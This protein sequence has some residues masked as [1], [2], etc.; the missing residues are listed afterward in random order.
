MS[1]LTYNNILQF[2]NILLITIKYEIITDYLKFINFISSTKILL[3]NY[4]SQLKRMSKRF[5]TITFNIYNNN[6]DG[7]YTHT[8]LKNAKSET[9]IVSK[10]VLILAIREINN[11]EKIK[12]ILIN[13]IILTIQKTN[14]I[15]RIDQTSIITKQILFESTNS[16]ELI[17]FEQDYNPLKDSDYQKYLKSYNI[18]MDINDLYKS[19][20]KLNNISIEIIDKNDIKNDLLDISK[21]IN[22][23]ILNLDN[24]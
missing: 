9:T 5:Q 20:N 18:Q 17:K 3:N 10:I 7:T 21:N 1:Q 23:I 2:D 11:Q 6:Q 22:N 19:I 4:V 16:K 13:D 8:M 12:E 15:S 24:Y 14:L